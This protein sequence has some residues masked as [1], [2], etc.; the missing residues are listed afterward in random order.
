MA[1]PQNTHTR[2]SPNGKHGV[3]ECKKINKTEY[4]Y[5]CRISSTSHDRNETEK[6]QRF[7]FCFI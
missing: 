4:L 6:D 5:T 7:F 2:H 3:N 1:E